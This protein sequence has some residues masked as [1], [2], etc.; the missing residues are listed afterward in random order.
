MNG[1][2]FPKVL[3]HWFYRDPSLIAESQLITP[4]MVPCETLPQLSVQTPAQHNRYYTQA[5]RL[6][7]RSLMKGKS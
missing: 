6:H 7:I 3:P 1:L 5:R 4:V 2:R